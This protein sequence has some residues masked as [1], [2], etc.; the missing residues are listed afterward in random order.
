M[1]FCLLQ[2]GNVFELGGITRSILLLCGWDD[3]P[4]IAGLPP[5]LNLPVFICMPGWRVSYPRTQH[6]A[7]AYLL[8]GGYQKFLELLVH[9]KIANYFRVICL[10]LS[11]DRQYSSAVDLRKQ[12][13]NQRSFPGTDE[14]DHAHR[15]PQ[16]FLS[17]PDIHVS[18]DAPKDIKGR[19]GSK[20]KL[21]V[22]I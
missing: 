10:I 4:L 2:S 19:A 1:S 21:E 22:S 12:V 9:I 8:W 14:V 7:P 20:P 5:A 17:V 15:M 13:L 6:N 18:N 16:R 11:S 3:G